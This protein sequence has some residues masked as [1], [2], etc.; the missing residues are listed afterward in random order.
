MKDPR[1]QKLAHLL[2]NHSLKVQKGEKVLIQ[3]NNVQAE[4]VKA[5]VK[6]IYAVEAYPFVSLKDLTI[7]RELMFGATEEQLKI[8]A[9]IE[10]HEM[11]QMDC[12]IGFRAINNL[13]AQCDVPAEKMAMY[14]KFYYEP[15]H[16]QRRLHHTRWVVLRYP[17]SAM[18]QLSEMSEEA[19]ED[20]FFEV[21]CL[22][23]SKM[24]KAMDNLVA[25][26]EKTDKVR[27]FSEATSTNKGTDFTFSIKGMNA[28]K[29]DGSA[30]IPDGEV[31]TAPVKNSVNGR[32]SYNTHSLEG[33]FLYDNISFVFKDGKIIE[34]TAN[35]S[36]RINTVLNTDEGARYIGE[37]AIG[38]NPFILYPMKET[39]FDEKIA[40]SIHFTPGNSYDDCDNGNKSAIHWD[41]VLIQR[42]EFGGG[43]IY[44]DDVLIRKDGIFV[45]PDLLCLNPEN[46]K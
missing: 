1:I 19:F 9:D 33:G 10:G 44:F 24:S 4:L 8:R 12:F 42:P 29:C 26:M 13:Y 43:E 37:F 30:N 23:Y 38:V 35:D 40:G 2:V 32:I 39:L 3:N 17:T 18:A 45:H 25:L 46:L 21:C 6:E 14:D 15:V 5:L 28:V 31:Y 22:D 11:A 16:M 41:L 34:A 7:E 20:F 27:I 36:D